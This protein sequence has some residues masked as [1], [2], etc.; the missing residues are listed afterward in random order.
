LCF[1]IYTPRKKKPKH[2]DKPINDLKKP[3]KSHNNLKLTQ[4]KKNLPE[5][6]SDF[7]GNLKVKKHLNGTPLMK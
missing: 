1:F 6:K 4:N 5:L 2:L 7:L 3:K